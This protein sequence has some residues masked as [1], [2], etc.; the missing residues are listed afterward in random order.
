MSNCEF[1]PGCPFFNNKMKGMDSVKE[2]MK[3]RYCMGEFSKCARYMV[4]TKSGKE[5]VPKNL[6]PN[7]QD[8]AAKL[9]A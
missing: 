4:C 2:L 6:F 5:A 3:K 7:Q 8:R 9:L 1:L